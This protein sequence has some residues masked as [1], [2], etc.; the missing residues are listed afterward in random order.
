MILSFSRILIELDL[1]RSRYA[2]ETLLSYPTANGRC[3]YCM[4]VAEDYFEYIDELNNNGVII[5]RNVIIKYCNT[6]FRSIKR[7]IK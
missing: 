6:N 3:I 1:Y 2:N 5:E 7:E 4:S